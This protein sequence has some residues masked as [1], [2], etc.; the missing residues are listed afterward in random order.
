MPPQGI[1]ETLGVAFVQDVLLDQAPAGSV[2]PCLIVP[3]VVDKRAG[4][5]WL[6]AASRP[7]VVCGGAVAGRRGKGIRRFRKLLQEL[8]QQRG[9]AER[10]ALLT[11]VRRQ[12]DV[13]G[14]VERQ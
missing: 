13:D 1:V 11:G 8:R 7:V 6:Q 10:L 5:L 9:G 3:F 14:H 4:P 2:G 12:F